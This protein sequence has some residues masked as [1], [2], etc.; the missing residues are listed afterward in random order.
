MNP[1][2]NAENKGTILLVDDIPENLQLLSEILL[3]YNYIVRRVT[4][5]KMALKTVKIKP[6]DVILLD[7]K[8]PEMD[9]YEVCQALKADPDFR[10][11]CECFR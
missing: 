4:S 8:M 7:I 10:N 3:T 2:P 6:P 9:G 11:F 5:G 1:N